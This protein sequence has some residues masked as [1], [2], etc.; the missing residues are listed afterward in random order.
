MKAGN[1]RVE[2]GLICAVCFADMPDY[3]VRVRGGKQKGVCCRC[4]K[5]QP[6]TMQCQFIRRWRTLT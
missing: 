2:S 4:G 5:Q 6:I 3:V 1:E